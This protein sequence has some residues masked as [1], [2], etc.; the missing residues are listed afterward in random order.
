MRWPAE[1]HMP[2][3]SQALRKRLQSETR[4]AQGTVPYVRIS[5]KLFD[6]LLRAAN[7]SREPGEGRRFVGM[8][9][10]GTPLKRLSE[11]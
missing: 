1:Q 9:Y 6:E 3:M 10:H 7:R 5:D 2:S 11:R 4:V 8:S